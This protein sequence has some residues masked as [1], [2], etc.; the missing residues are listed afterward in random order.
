MFGLTWGRKKAARLT[1]GVDN[2]VSGASPI[3]LGLTNYKTNIV[4]GG[5]AADE[6]AVLP[7]GEYPGQR[8]LVVMVT[9]TNA[10]DKVAFN[11]T[12]IRRGQILTNTPAAI[13]TFKLGTAGMLALFEW[14]GSF[15]NIVYTD[16]TI[17]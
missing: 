5:T 12:N 11:V 1:P 13:A 14:T 4:T 15:W 9:R 3:T 16:G 6:S 7:A 17:T 10:A 8:K 2:V